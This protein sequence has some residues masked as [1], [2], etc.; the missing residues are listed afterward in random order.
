MNNIRRLASSDRVSG[1][2]MLSFAFLG[3]LLANLPATY[4]FFEHVSEFHIGIPETDIVMPV[5]H[6]VQDGLLTVFFFVV[7]LELKQELTTGS[8]SDVRA[9]AVPMVAAAGGMAVPPLI[10]LGVSSM[11]FK[12]DF[13][14]NLL[15]PNADF[16]QIVPGCAIPTAT[17]IAFS[18][19]VLALFAKGLP[20]SIRAFLLTLATVDD[21]LGI[22][23]IAICFSDLNEWYWFA[24]IAVCALIWYYLVRLEKVPKILVAFTGL[25]AWTMM[26]EAGVHPT[27]AGVLVGLLTPA[28]PIWG[29]KQ[30]RSQRY[31]EIM[32]P[33]SVLVALP[34]F[35]L[36]ATGIHFETVNAQLFLSP[37]F[38]A[39]ASALLLGKP[40]G[41]LLSSWIS[42]HILRLKLPDG[43]KVRDFIPA[44]TACGI[45]FTVSFLIAS[46]AY[47]DHELIDIARFA[48][49]IGSVV[50]AAVASFLLNAQV[51]RRKREHADKNPTHIGKTHSENFRAETLSQ[52]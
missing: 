15:P 10:F 7:G 12:I 47:K 22:L 21:L 26:F 50:S 48:V 42:V 30:S 51:K 46:L 20:G 8:L 29:E 14:A 39:I 5:G 52:I 44:G 6:W 27:L 17:D 1:I 9:A 34:V 11:T 31:C 28:L 37:V 13:F 35:A 36:F 43:L 16:S 38:L 25:A 19:T 24:G 40:L 32:Q 18:L 33:F 3:L 2:I 49:L 45:G 23:V 41:V 4:P